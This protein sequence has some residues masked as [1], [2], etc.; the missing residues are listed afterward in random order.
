MAGHKQT[1]NLGRGCEYEYIIIHEI[2]HALGFWHE[3]SRPDRDSYVT[4]KFENVEPGLESQFAKRNDLEVDYQDSIYDYGSI[5]QYSTK[6]FADPKCVGCSTMVVANTAEYV[7]QGSPPLGRSHTLSIMD[8][9]QTKRLYS[10]P[11]RGVQGFLILNVERGINLPSTT[12]NFF[13]APDPY[14]K[15]TAV[16]SDG[17]KVTRKTTTKDDTTQPVWKEVIYFKEKEW[18]FV[19][20]RVWDEDGFLNGNDDIMSMSQTV[21]LKSGDHTIIHCV[22]ECY[23]YVKLN[24]NLLTLIT[25]RL[26]VTIFSAQNLP[27][28]DPVFDDPD[29]YVVVRAIDSTGEVHIRHTGV[30]SG[31]RNPVWNKSIDFGCR[32]WVMIYLQVWDEDGYFNG[33]DDKMTGEEN[34]IVEG[35][36]HYTLYYRDGGAQLE[37]DYGLLGCA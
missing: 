5:M 36:Q 25:A 29:P 20:I 3:Q 16:D 35:G 19:K 33:N 18:Q 28:T 17:I 15:I 8:I 9:A 23:R 22:G 1:I 14:V 37:Y 2:G 4:V 24:Y 31:D 27:D 32:R 11:G 6:A 12:E 34:V 10:C 7:K 30:V 21:V 13:G 26:T